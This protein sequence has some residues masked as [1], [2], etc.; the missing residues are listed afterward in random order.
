VSGPDA[1]GTVAALVRLD[2]ALDS[3]EF[4]TTLV[5]GPGRRPCLTVASRRTPA[6]E[7]L[8]ADGAWFWWAW[9]QP[10]CPVE[11]PLTAAHRVTAMLRATPGGWR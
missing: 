2:T 10:V 7:H 1:P 4:A 5:Y 9:G 11:D 3:G 8:F 6:A